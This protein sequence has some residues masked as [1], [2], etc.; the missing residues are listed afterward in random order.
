MG[1]PL[2]QAF[3]RAVRGLRVGGS[4]VVK[5]A[6]GE[7][8]KELLFAVPRSHE[9]MARLEAEAAASGGLRE[10]AE[11]RRAAGCAWR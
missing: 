5:A 2:F 3:D 4:A 7:Y 6:G 10:G 11:T 1:N 8:N 9:E